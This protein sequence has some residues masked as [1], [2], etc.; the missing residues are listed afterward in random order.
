MVLLT[1]PAPGWASLVFAL[2]VASDLVDG[3]I[4]RARGEATSGGTFFDH[5]ADAWFV[6]FGLLAYAAR[7]PLTPLLPLGIALSFLEY[8]WPYLRRREPVRGSPLGRFNGV[9]YYALLGTLLGA[10]VLA[11]DAFAAG[12]A[13]FAGAALVATTVASVLLRRRSRRFV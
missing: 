5:A 9:A 10:D 7:L 2:A 6:T 12:V 13:R 8:G 3:R 11:W 4:A 1:R